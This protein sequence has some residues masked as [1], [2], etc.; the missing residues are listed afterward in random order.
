MNL[1]SVPP[2][3]PKVAV[4]N[5]VVSTGTNAQNPNPVS[6]TNAVEGEVR[7]AVPVTP[8]KKGN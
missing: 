3:K 6:Q 5:P 1:E 8:V 2:F 7:R 4:S